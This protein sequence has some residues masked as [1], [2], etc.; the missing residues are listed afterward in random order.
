V[1][2]GIDAGLRGADSRGTE[3]STEGVVLARRDPHASAPRRRAAASVVVA[4]EA[5][6]CGFVG[7]GGD[8]D[9]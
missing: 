9:G 6:A 8:R 2:R 7:R 4:P 3:Q 1:A 5:L